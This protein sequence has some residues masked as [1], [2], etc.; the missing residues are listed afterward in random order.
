MNQNLAD[1]TIGVDATIKDALQAINVG[2]HGI[3][4]VCDGEHR[5][6][7]TL[8]DGD[9][10]RAILGDASLD[11][12]CVCRAMHKEFSF[13][14]PAE[15][16]ADV[17]D[18]MHARDID[19]VPVLDSEKRLVGLHLLH[20]LIG[21]V[22][23]DNWA[24][25]MAGGRGVRLRP[26]TENV[27][28]P[29]LTVAGRPILERMV[30]HL[31]RW[32]VRRVFLSVNYM[33][34]VIEEHFGD[35]SRHGC[36]IEYLHE[37]QPLG[38]GGALSLLPRA[39][40]LPLLVLNGDLITQV[41]IDRLLSF[42]DEGEYVATFGVR[43]YRVDIPYGVA[44]V[45]EGRVLSLRE[46]PTQQVLVSAGVYVLAPSVLQM[47]PNDRD[48]PI[49]DLFQR[50]LKENLTVGGHIILD[51]WTDV[52]HHDELRKARGET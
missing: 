50:C 52:G 23:R 15:G 3:A 21:S 39:P 35:G 27:P 32:G 22:Q 18:M 5:V 4:F 30:L 17:L 10:R 19:Q 44:E 31:V 41:N 24:V 28:K 34:E 20:E 37:H 9:I 45:V 40:E 42:H 1:M 6:L 36:Q 47:V 16:R 26:L 25:I 49:T 13:V 46:K 14:G 29:M 7:G 8:T 43:P 2:A 11:S 33:S 12:R 51:E 38:T 48:F